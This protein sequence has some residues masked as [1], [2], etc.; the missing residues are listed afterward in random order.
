MVES[1][2]Q[3]D[4]IKLNQKISGSSPSCTHKNYYL[5]PNRR[6]RDFMGREDVLGRIRRGFSSGSTPRV[7]VIRGPGGQGKSQVALEHCHR[8]KADI[9]RAIFWVDAVNENMLK[10]S[11]ESIAERIKS[12]G[13]IL[14]EDARVDFVLESLRDW[15][16]R[17]LMVFDNYDDPKGFP[18]LQDF[19]P[20]GEHGNLL[21]T[22]R[23]ADVVSLADRDNAIELHGLAEKEAL[24]LL[25][26]QSMVEETES[27]TQHGKVIV[28]RLGYHPLA[29]T[30]AGSYISQQRID[31]SEFMDH[32]N[33]RR[34]AILSQTPQMSPYRR[35]LSDADKETALNVFTT[36]ELSFQ[37]LEA[38]E[39]GNKRIGDIL[40]LFAFFDCND[41][42]EQL[43]K[44]FCNREEFALIDAGG[45]DGS[46]RFLLDS[47]ERWDSDAFVDILNKL[48]D[49]SLVQAWWRDKEDGYSHLSLHP[50][51]KD[52]ILLRTDW[53]SCQEYFL[54][55]AQI[56]AALIRS[57]DKYGMH[58]LPLST[59]LLVLSHID[60][61]EEAMIFFT[62]DL[63]MSNSD[64]FWITLAWAESSFVSFLT[65]RGRYKEAE[66]VGRR[67]LKQGTKN[68]G[69]EHTDTLTYAN[70]LAGS[71]FYQ[72]KNEEAVML[73]RRVR[74]G[75]EKMYGSMHQESMNSLNNLAI[76]LGS[77]EN[78]QE[79][80][81]M[82]RSAIK[83][84]EKGLVQENPEIPRSFGILGMQLEH[85]GK[86]EEA[87]VMY[88]LVVE[89]Y[90]R[91]FGSEHPHTLSWLW[92]LSK[93]LVVQNEYDKALPL[94]QR[95]VCGFQKVYGPDH[96][97]TLK[98][99]E[100]YSTFLEE[101]KKMAPG[102]LE[103]PDTSSGTSE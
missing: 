97:E 85:Q 37:Q 12:N 51:V 39:W 47:E 36:W 79:A 43:F 45:P 52:W 89:G 13:V 38:T 91:I 26:K 94:Y 99:C 98:I 15:P 29:I 50:L 55:A 11:F 101:L 60:A 8:A 93:L 48:A 59:N 82:L 33:R 1:N 41:I 95:A 27:Q 21:V 66:Y 2:H 58:N 96:P 54:A 57:C 73:L 34:L 5:V 53:K 49:V 92:S 32:Y 28:K 103:V 86:Y 17:W 4:A 87:K 69:P 72:G 3:A 71:L 6:V 70:E 75:R 20:M 30:Q 9:V 23:H 7:V 25:F 56:L 100:N 16:E 65:H 62:K 76:A 19:M 14:K 42:S 63:D 90:E 102:N 44:I 74:E 22:T 68:L 40:T 77:L 64:S 78:Y 67:V 24:S 83:R 88:Q 18:N 31:L 80:E 46:L 61:H 81:E 84:S 10:Q 35:K